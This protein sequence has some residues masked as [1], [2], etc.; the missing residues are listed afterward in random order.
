MIEVVWVA[1]LA[2]TLPHTALTQDAVRYCQRH[3]AAEGAAP[4]AGVILQAPVGGV[5]RVHGIN[6]QVGGGVCP[7][8]CRANAV[9]AGAGR[10]A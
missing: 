1:L 4:L 5:W 2:L 7:M 3:G 8:F 9:P 6:S 10:P